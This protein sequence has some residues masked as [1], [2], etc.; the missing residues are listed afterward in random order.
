M[1]NFSVPIKDLKKALSIVA[2]ATGDMV[3]TIRSHTLFRINENK[4]SITLYSTDE[5]KIAQASFFPSLIEG[6]II[7]FTADPKRILL[8]INNS[9]SKE[10]TFTYDSEK[11]TLNVYASENKDAYISFASFEP[12][13]FL[14]FNLKDQKLN[15]K[16]NSD[17]LLKGIKFI[18][19]FLPKDDKNK[20]FSNL[21]I[22]KGVMYGSDGDTKI[23]AFKSSEFKEIPELSL[24]KQML[25]I[26]IRMVEKTKISEINIKSSD[27]YITLSSENDIYYFGFRQS[28]IKKPKL[29]ISIEIPETDGFNVHRSTFIKKLN[30]LSLSSWEDIA[31][32]SSYGEN[33]ILEMKTL[34]ERPSFEKLPCKRVSGS[35]KVR[36]LMECGKFKNVLGLFQAPDVNFYLKERR[37]TI[38]SKADII[39]EEKDKEPL[40]KYVTAI[41]LLTLSWERES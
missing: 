26:I 6:D 38:Y 1:I 17:V 22:E 37:C 33:Q 28:I 31:I 29:P 23:G 4:E 30:R 11:K 13:E 14:N 2:L 41:A 21:F 16:V 5:D 35:E 3:N 36:F 20:K 39:I 34:T 15:G 9:D 24:R 8:L 12:K 7:E 32:D 19:G 18:Q 25:P 10:I 27:K 40:K